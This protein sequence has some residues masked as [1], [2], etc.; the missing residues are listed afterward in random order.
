MTP[1]IVRAFRFASTAARLVPLA[2]SM[3]IARGVGRLAGRLDGDRRRLVARNLQRVVGPELNGRQLQ[4]SVSRVFASYADYY[5]CLLYTSP[6][7]R[8]QR[9][10]RMPSSA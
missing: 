1:G 9:G 3:P 2:V 4:R 5:L 10:S 6:S 8:D 7:P